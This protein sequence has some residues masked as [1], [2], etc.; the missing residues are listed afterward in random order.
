MDLVGCP[1]TSPPHIVFFIF[2]VYSRL[3]FS[4]SDCGGRKDKDGYLDTAETERQ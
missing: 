4:L 2:L 3:V 1:Y